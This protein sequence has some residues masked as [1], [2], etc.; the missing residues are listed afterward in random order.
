MEALA[1]VVRVPAPPTQVPPRPLLCLVVGTGL[2]TAPSAV[3]CASLPCTVGH[4]QALLL[5]QT[6]PTREAFPAV[7]RAV[8]LRPSR[9]PTSWSPVL[10]LR[11]EARALRRVQVVGVAL[12]LAPLLASTA[13]GWEF[14]QDAIRIVP[15]PM[16]TFRRTTSSLAVAQIRR[17]VPCAARRVRQVTWPARPSPGDTPVSPGCGAVRPFKVA[18]QTDAPC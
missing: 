3:A 18:R 2:R 5:A 6:E 9:K 15:V 14:S 12:W 4:Q 1:V 7:R 10:P 11:T 16:L 8:A 13:R 17:L